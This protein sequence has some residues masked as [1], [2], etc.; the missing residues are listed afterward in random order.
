MGLNPASIMIVAILP[1]LLHGSVPMLNF[2][3]SWR[4]DSPGPIPEEVNNA[5]LE[6]IGRIATP[7]KRLLCERRRYEFQL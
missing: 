3:G 2:D 4:F 1:H 6:L 7:D 5:F